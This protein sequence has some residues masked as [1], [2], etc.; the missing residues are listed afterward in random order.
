MKDDRLDE[1]LNLTEAALETNTDIAVGDKPEDKQDK[2]VSPIKAHLEPPEHAAFAPDDR[3]NIGHNTIA[4]PQR[5]SEVNA[6]E[7]TDLMPAISLPDN[8]RAQLTSAGESKVKVLVSNEPE[9][10]AGRGTSTYSK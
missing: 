2:T 8:N 4:H 9:R 5:P 3:I 7:L 10:R 1:Q 6:E